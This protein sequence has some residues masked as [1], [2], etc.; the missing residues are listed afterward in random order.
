MKVIL[1]QE[2]KGK[3]SEGDVVEVARGFAVNYL[4][5][6][7]MAVEA[8]SGNL[9]QL[10]QRLHNIRKREELRAA[11]AA[12][13]ARS[14]EGKAV[15]I[16]AKAGE[17]G[18]LYGSI[19]PQMIESAIAEQLGVSVDRRKMDVP[20]H[21]KQ[22]GDQVVSVHVY[23]G[24]KAD[25]IVRVM[26]EEAQLSAAVATANAVT[27]DKTAT[28]SETKTIGEPDASGEE[29]KASGEDSKEPG[30]DVDI[31]EEA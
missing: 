21:I 6:R 2:V 11:E 26:A 27:D 19:T 9:K 31:V 14:L 5:P 28:T 25:V 4:F 16:Y 15:V 30:G 10:E 3:G 7:K 23:R 13:V 12:E 17:E 29:A 18:R 24:V 20:G 8:T 1:T 22:I